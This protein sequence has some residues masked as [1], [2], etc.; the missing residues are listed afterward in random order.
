VELVPALFGVYV[1][2]LALKGGEGIALLIADV[3]GEDPFR[4]GEGLTELVPRH[5]DLTGGATAS[6]PISCRGPR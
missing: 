5:Y 3:V 1:G 4:D 2:E 6:S